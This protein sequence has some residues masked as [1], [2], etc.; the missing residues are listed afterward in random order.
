MARL[1][2]ETTDIVN[3]RSPISARSPRQE[4]ARDQ[5]RWRGTLFRYLDGFPIAPTI[6]ALDRHS[7]L[8][9]FE[10]E[11]TWSLEDVVGRCDGNEG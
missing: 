11:Q 6:T 2:V 9:L 8:D 5:A 10:E 4:L 7:V 1:V 3:E